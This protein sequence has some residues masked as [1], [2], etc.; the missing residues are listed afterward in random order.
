MS[1]KPTHI[2]TF[3]WRMDTLTTAEERVAK[4]K[5]YLDWG[6]SRARDPKSAL[7]PP[8][9]GRQDWQTFIEPYLRV[10]SYATTPHPTIN[11]R[12]ET[13][14]VHANGNGNMHGGCTATL[15]DFCTSWP[16]HIIARPGFW[17]HL[18]VSRTLNCTYLRPVP[19]GAV[20]DIQCEVVQAGQKMGVTRG[21]MR[22]VEKDGSL[23][24]VLTICEHGKFNTDP[25]APKL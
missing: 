12:L 7:T 20:I 23:G 16:L 14:P 19:I 13:Q 2:E 6:R 24:P 18:G 17:Q 5:E 8:T 15:F 25:P 1:A 21:T 4:V 3:D 22:L 10:H 11:F 9:R